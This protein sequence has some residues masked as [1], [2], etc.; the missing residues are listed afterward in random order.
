MNI[1]REITRVD[2]LPT[3]PESVLEVQR[4]ADAEDA[5]AKALA[6]IIQRDP[7]LAARLLRV[8]NSAFYSARSNPVSSVQFAITR[9]GFQEV[10]RIALASSVIEQFALTFNTINY[11]SFWRHSLAAAFLAQR[12]G[13]REESPLSA[14]KNMLYL[15][16]L[17]HDIGL[18]IYDRFYPRIFD[19]VNSHALVTTS[20]YLS[21]EQE[22]LGK[23]AHCFVGGALLEVWRLDPCAV[24]AVRYHHLPEKAPLRFNLVAHALA[25]VE[26]LLGEAD[27]GCI[28]GGSG[29]PESSYEALAITREEAGDILAQTRTSL[30]SCDSLISR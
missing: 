28:E 2:D 1:L 7:A 13:A 12:I 15:A 18:L 8:A 16:G 3:I 19:E 11:Y 4:L 9:L 6:T 5:D 25:L 26:H 10:A 30:A 24:A 29:S 17:L 23:E 22:L 27:L 14:E 21:A 20:T